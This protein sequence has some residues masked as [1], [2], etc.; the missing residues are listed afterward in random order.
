MHHLAPRPCIRIELALLNRAFRLAVK[1]KRLS[2]RGRPDIELPP[3]D[4]TSIHQGFFRHRGRPRARVAR[5]TPSP[6]APWR[7]AGS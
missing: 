3:E 6:N 7:C 2:P 5:L 1:K 4:E